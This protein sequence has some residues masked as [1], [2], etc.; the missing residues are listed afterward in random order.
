MNET[1]STSTRGEDQICY[2]VVMLGDAGVGKTCIVNR[3]VKGAFSE[4]DATL[5]SNYSSK[6]LHIQPDGVLSPTKVKL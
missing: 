2:K 1:S 4:Q 5:G 3:Y 6:V